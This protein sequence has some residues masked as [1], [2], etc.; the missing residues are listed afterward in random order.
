M[1]HLGYNSKK[2][3]LLWSG[4]LED[5]KT[6]IQS[7]LDSSEEFSVTHDTERSIT[8]K[9][10]LVTLTFYKNTKTLQIQ[11]SNAQE[12]KSK[13]LS[14]LDPGLSVR[15][16]A[17]IENPDA[18]QI[19]RH[20]Q[21]SVI[22][23]PEVSSDSSS[24]VELDSSFSSTASN[25]SNVEDENYDGDVSGIAKRPFS[26]NKILQSEVD[27]MKHE[28]TK[29][30]AYL[31]NVSV[32]NNNIQSGKTTLEL[33]I[34][35]KALQDEIDS[36][37]SKLK[38]TEDERDSFKLALQLVAKDY[39]LISSMKSNQNIATNKT[40]YST[41]G[42]QRMTTNKTTDPSTECNQKVATDKVN[43]ENKKRKKK[44]KT[45]IS[46]KAQDTESKNI[47]N[48]NQQHVSF[49][50]IDLTSHS[51]WAN[52]TNRKKENQKVPAAPP[53]KYR[54][55]QPI[56]TTKSNG[57]KQLPPT[58]SDAPSPSTTTTVIIGDSMI[59]NVHG[60]KL[61]KQV[62][63]RVVVKS[64]PGATTD[65]MTH[66]LKPT[67]D[68]DPQKIV[69]HIG[70]N[71]L[72]KR[73]PYE[74]S[75]NIIDLARRIE[76]NTNAQVFISELVVRS[77]DASNEAVKAVNQRLRKFCN[78]QDLQL[79]RHNNITTDDLNKG[80]LHLNEKGTS[81][82]FTNFANKLVNSH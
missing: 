65:E 69:L 31:H 33:E 59:K 41:K 46:S 10:N 4:S 80:G 1:E 72:R 6:F 53:N 82:M 56:S 24:E 36:L 49:D 63:H 26:S 34:T 77:D 74:V 37:K 55:K 16:E 76:T 17:T 62:G 43:K 51:N 52:H 57:Q 8:L 68:R 3:L 19:S 66:Y 70:T 28:L 38:A 60:W 81:I 23:L 32:N 7:K 73:Q 21:S 22:L 40:N 78:Q 64:F 14:Y 13:L 15:I 5:L 11:G 61:G 67:L 12:L 50:S 48:T 71:D 39:S 30:W 44:S 27:S 9:T 45:L 35:H 20:D 25:G 54:E 79:V 58:H 18:N 42:N 29:I 75:D 2:S 47:R